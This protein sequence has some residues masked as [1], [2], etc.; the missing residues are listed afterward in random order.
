MK[1][2]TQTLLLTAALLPVTTVAA[3]VPGFDVLTAMSVSDF[4]ATGLDKLS[5][6][7][8]K[9]LDV[10][11]AEYQKQHACT[12]TT[13]AAVNPAPVPALSAEDAYPL[14][15]HLVGKFT[16][17]NGGT[18]FTLDN[19]EVWQQTDDSSFTTG[20]ILNPKVTISRGLMHAYYLSVESV[21]DTVLVRRIKP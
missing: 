11:F 15:A 13:A 19:G 7:Q 9:A 20:A 8:I 1:I 10:W 18:T 2:L 5:E 12:D 16:G 3:D 17:W 4:R 21:K 14:S 6:A